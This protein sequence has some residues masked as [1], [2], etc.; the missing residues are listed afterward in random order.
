[1]RH[2]QR[3]LLAG[4]AIAALLLGAAIWFTSLRQPALATA[5]QPPSTATALPPSLA[6]IGY[7]PRGLQ[8]AALATRP[9]PTA[10]LTVTPEDMAALQASETP[11]PKP[12]PVLSPTPTRTPIHQPTDRDPTRLTIPVLDLDT[13][14][15]TVGIDTISDGNG[16]QMSVWQVADY[17]AGFHQGTA[18]VGHVGNTVMAGHNN[19]RGKVFENLHKLKP[20]DEVFVWV[21]DWPFRYL[22]SASYRLPVKD[23]PEDILID[24]LRWI[25]PT[26][27]QRLTLVTCWPPWGNSHRTIV[28]AYPA[29][30]ED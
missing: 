9:N 18:R 6:T 17:A 28:V 20:G 24:N 12:T 27:D 14:V 25:L 15:V 3:R 29:P 30:W 19:I 8:A 23:A 11:S 7:L 4:M 10:T 2:E 21:D 16:G 26:Q 5:T 22:V 1:M 13:P